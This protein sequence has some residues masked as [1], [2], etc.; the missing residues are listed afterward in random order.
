MIN[1][2]SERTQKVLFFSYILSF[3]AAIP[4]YLWVFDAPMYQYLFFNI[5]SFMHKVDSSGFLIFAGIASGIIYTRVALVFYRNVAFLSGFA[6]AISQASIAAMEV[7]ES[8]YFIPTKMQTI[9]LITALMSGGAFVIFSLLAMAAYE[10]EIKNDSSNDLRNGGKECSSSN[11]SLNLSVK[12]G[13]V[14]PS[15]APSDLALDLRYS[16]SRARRSLG[17]R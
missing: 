7:P 6:F 9:C 16:R 2:H 8:V 3:S 12:S 11:I 15:P 14:Q 1:Y 17:R 10:Y 13:S 5:F 4:I